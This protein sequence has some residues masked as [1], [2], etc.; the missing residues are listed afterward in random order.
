MCTC[1]GVRLWWRAVRFCSVWGAL[2]SGVVLA[3]ISML[4]CT[5]G[6]VLSSLVVCSGPDMFSS[7]QDVVCFRIPLMLGL[8]ALYVRGV[9]D[10]CTT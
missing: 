1:A 8:G 9:V 10:E 3:L 2:I 7:R 5:H 6:H 4:A